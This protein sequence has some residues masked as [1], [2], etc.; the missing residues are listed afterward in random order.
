MTP[1][2]DWERGARAALEELTAADHRIGRVP[3]DV[4]ALAV[5]C[6]QHSGGSITRRGPITSP[7]SCS[8]VPE[9]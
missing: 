3:I 8:G 6:Q 2:E 5:W 1:F 7:T 4:E 9:D